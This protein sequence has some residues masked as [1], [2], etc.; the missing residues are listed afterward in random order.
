MRRDLER[1]PM[2]KALALASQRDPTLPSRSGRR[3]YLCFQA[4]LVFRLHL[5]ILGAANIVLVAQSMGPARPEALSQTVHPCFHQL[6]RRPPGSF[7]PHDRSAIHV[8]LHQSYSGL[9]IGYVPH[10]RRPISRIPRHAISPLLET[11]SLCHK[12]STV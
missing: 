4:P 7:T 9:V 5:D 1:N 12:R 3:P 10:V 11:S 8:L 2:K 6:L